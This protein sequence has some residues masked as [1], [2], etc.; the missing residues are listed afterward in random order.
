MPGRGN[1][2]KELAP[3]GI[4]TEAASDGI[5]KVRVQLDGIA[6]AAAA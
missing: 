4:A 1:V 2:P 5:T 6:T 3:V